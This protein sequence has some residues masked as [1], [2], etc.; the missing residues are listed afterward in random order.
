MLPPAKN[1]S[2]FHQITFDLFQFLVGRTYLARCSDAVGGFA[3]ARR[4]DGMTGVR[5]STSRR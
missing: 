2:A 5:F 4:S 3:Y 1:D